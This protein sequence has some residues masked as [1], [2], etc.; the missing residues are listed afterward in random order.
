MRR[1]RPLAPA[2][3]L[4]HLNSQRRNSIFTELKDQILKDPAS[5]TALTS[6]KRRGAK[7]LRVLH[8]ATK[9]P[10]ASSLWIHMSWHLQNAEYSCNS[11]M[12]AFVAE[13]FYTNEDGVE[14]E[15]ERDDTRTIGPPA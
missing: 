8:T 5:A 2:S 14:D 13:E 1:N 12:H 11:E 4:S 9:D 3:R 15:D 6:L 7:A 10:H